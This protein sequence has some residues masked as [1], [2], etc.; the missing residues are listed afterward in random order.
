MVVS[1][2]LSKRLVGI[3]AGLPSLPVDRGIY[4]LGRIGPMR[5]RG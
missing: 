4:A 5:D 3:R 2:G 1:F